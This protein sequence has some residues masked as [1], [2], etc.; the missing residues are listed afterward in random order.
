[1]YKI[2]QIE[3]GDTLDLIALKTNTTIDE[4]K[5]INGINNNYDISVGE[6]IIVPNNDNEMFSTYIVNTGETLWSIAQSNNIDIDTLLKLNGLDEKDY[7]YPNQEIIIP[8][9]NV[10]IYITKYN[11][12]VQDVLSNLGVDIVTLA[13][14]NN[15][16]FVVEDQL[17][18]HKKEKE[19]N[20]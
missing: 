8:N 5:R 9:S 12:T 20:E 7:I 16:I 4:L 2:Y 18:L 19:I 1:M 13:N 11:D 15:K 6:L 10:D 17:M 14:E 3:Y